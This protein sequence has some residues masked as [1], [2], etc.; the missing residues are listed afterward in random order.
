[1]FVSF[2]AVRPGRLAAGLATV[3]YLVLATGEAVSEP[4][5]PFVNLEFYLELLRGSKNDKNMKIELFMVN[6]GLLDGVL[7]ASQAYNERGAPRRICPPADAEFNIAGSFFQAIG[8]E[9]MA[10]PAYYD[11]PEKVDMGEV[12]LFALQ[13]R[14]PCR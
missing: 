7:A 13:R 10:H 14:F 6:E 2:A 11:P 9:L 4:A 8:A 5:K 12:T 1:M 3:L